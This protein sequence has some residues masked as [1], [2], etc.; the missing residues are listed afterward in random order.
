MQCIHYGMSNTP[1][2]DI[3]EY[4]NTF[5]FIHLSERHSLYTAVT[6]ATPQECW[7]LCVG[8]EI[9]SVKNDNG[10]SIDCI[11][12]IIIFF[13]HCLY[14]SLLQFQEY[15]FHRSSSSTPSTTLYLYTFF[16]MIM[17]ILWK[18]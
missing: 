5:A 12:Q 3:A 16:Y 10:N 13:C 17:C 14:L 15:M 4:S 7:I 11:M 8:T 18:F 1:R 6:R 2:S 9:Q